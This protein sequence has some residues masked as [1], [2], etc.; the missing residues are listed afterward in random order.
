[1]KIVTSP[2]LDRVA[3]VRH[4]F[5]S[6]HGGVSTGIYDSLNVGRG[7][8]DEAEDVAENRRRCAAHFGRPADRLL[9]CYQI[10]STTV[11]TADGPWGDDRPQADGVVTA[12]PSLVCGALSADCAPILLA[13][14][15][16]RVV[17][18]A[19]AGWKG[20]LGGM[21]ESVVAQ[22][23]ALGCEP[24]RMVAAIGPC[25]GPASYEVGAEY[26]ERFTQADPGNSRFFAP[27]RSAGKSMFDLPAYVL[28]RL[29]AAGVGQME[30]VGVDTC[31]D[32]D[33]FS[34]RRAVLRQ[35]PDYGRLL[36]AIMLQ[37]RG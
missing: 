27:G 32:E 24:G 25:I 1:V 30:W 33:F 4:A 12:K 15:V 18:A 11:L 19:H 31:A 23:V 9:T 29:K 10:H 8:K 13:D 5:F 21:A 2:L 36:S 3:G 28:T 35:E 16:A 37:E 20:A 34:N 17:G 7:S 26:V 6:R 14:P 22:M